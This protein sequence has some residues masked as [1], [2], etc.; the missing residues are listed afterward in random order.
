MTAPA[1]A[2]VGALDTK[3]PEYGFVAERLRAAGVA[4]VLVDTGVLGEPGCRADVDRATVA[5]ASGHRI[6]DLRGAGDRNAAMA[7]MADGAATLLR[8]LHAAGELAGVLAL[9]GSNAGF[10]MSRVAAALPFGC[11]KVLVSTIV[12]GDT[13]PY[14]GSSDLMMLYPV[15]DLA[16]LNSLSIPVL[17]HAADAL[18]GMVAGHAPRLPDRAAVVGATMFG[19]TTTCVDAVRVAAEHRGAEVDVF[20]ATGT[21]GRAFEAMIASGVFDAIAD[22]T[23]TELAD[24][25]L[26]GVCSAGPH[27]LEAAAAHG[28]P[29][30]VS[31]GALDMANFGSP[32]TLPDRFADRTT[33]AHNPHVTLVRTSP[34][35]C[36]ELGRILAAKV[37]RS[38]AFVEVHV[39]LRGF[40]QI[41]GPGGPFHDP[42]ADAALVAALESG[43]DRRIPLHLHDHTIEDADFASA[44]S[45]ALDRALA[46][47]EGPRP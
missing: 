46:S 35:E 29:Q 1:V 17:A 16:G 41:S 38:A 3:A 39:P 12:A 30:V 33:L 36:A 15:V 10:V 37:N 31:V 40:S 2:L 20:H 18:A 24:E 28:V 34:E 7:A 42:A 5:A 26:G 32:E 4:T 6:D 27:R 21:G 22:V 14:V 43:L 13:R 47:T 45:Q 19:V 8:D 44:I 23:T 25:L 11:P 9:G